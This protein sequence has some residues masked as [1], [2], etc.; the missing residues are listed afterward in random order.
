MTHADL[1]RIAARWLKKTVRCGVVLAEPP[2]M[3]GESPDAIGWR[4]GYS[5]LVECKVSRSDFLA[6]LR[7][8]HRVRDSRLA[9]RC[10]YLTPV[11]LL[12][13]EEVPHPWGLLEAAGRCVR[14]VREVPERFKGDWLDERSADD[15]RRE[16]RLLWAELRRYHAQGI[17][18]KTM[19]GKVAQSH[20]LE[21]AEAIPAVGEVAES[22][23]G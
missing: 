23:H 17:T 13:P 3:D 16:V 20:L 9:I 18:Y 7:K 1:V 5:A 22:G 11:G 12:R 19:T 14:V 8:P 15:V 6:D 21:L 2:S 4:S 10:Y